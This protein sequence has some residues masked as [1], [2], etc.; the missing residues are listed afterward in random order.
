MMRSP[1][2][3]PGAGAGGF[4][5]PGS[6]AVG[7]SRSGSEPGEA[8]PPPGQQPGAHEGEALESV[9][10]LLLPRDQPASACRWPPRV[11]ALGLARRLFTEA[12]AIPGPTLR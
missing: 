11:D 10:A 8:P 5:L 4:H 3:S 1:A 12:C 6:G 9:A 7:T 2:T